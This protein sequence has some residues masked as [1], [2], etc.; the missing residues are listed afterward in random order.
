MLKIVK[1][2]KEEKKEKLKVTKNLRRLVNE[3]Y[4]NIKMNLTYE[5]KEVKR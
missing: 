5:A 2:K 4:P 3:E 1:L